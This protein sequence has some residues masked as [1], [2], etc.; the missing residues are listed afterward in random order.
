M[1]PKRSYPRWRFLSTFGA[2]SLGSNSTMVLQQ[3]LAVGLS[4]WISA[5]NNPSLNLCTE[6]EYEAEAD[7]TGSGCGSGPIE[8]NKIR[9]AV[10]TH[11]N[12]VLWARD[13]VEER[14]EASC[15]T[16]GLIC[17][18]KARMC[19]APSEIST[20]LLLHSQKERKKV[21]TNCMQPLCQEP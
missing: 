20:S 1:S 6:V 11:D 3:M 7:E 19:L 10:R 2:N 8:P 15:G 9:R 13:G 16:G 17:H 21:L 12:K 14:C 18:Y 4:T 5:I